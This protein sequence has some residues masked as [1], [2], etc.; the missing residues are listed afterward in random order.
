MDDDGGARDD[1]VAS[2][3]DTRVIAHCGACGKVLCESPDAEAMLAFAYPATRREDRRRQ[4]M[5]SDG[6]VPCATQG[7]LAVYEF[8]EIRRRVRDARRRGKRSV[9]IHPIAAPNV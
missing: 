1:S 6:R 2:M 5:A 7:C 9:K 8:E 3:S 4:D